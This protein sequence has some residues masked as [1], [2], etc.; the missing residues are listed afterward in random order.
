M[1]TSV[2]HSVF[3]CFFAV[4]LAFIFILLLPAPTLFLFSL[5]GL[6]CPGDAGIHP[7]MAFYNC[8]ASP[9]I[10]HDHRAIIHLFL[11]YIVH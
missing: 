3:L 9:G 7:Y 8:Y 11:F 4:R 5:H 2:F 1:D 6:H 10:I